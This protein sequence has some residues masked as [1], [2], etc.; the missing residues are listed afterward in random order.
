MTTLVAEKTPQAQSNEIH[1]CSCCGK[2]G[3]G[4][5]G[6]YYYVGGQGDVFFYECQ[7]CINDRLEASQ[8]A[9]NSMKLAMFMKSWGTVLP[10]WKE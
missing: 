8:K 6:N 9:V 10:C 4:M 1:T 2:T 3:A 7:D 5:V